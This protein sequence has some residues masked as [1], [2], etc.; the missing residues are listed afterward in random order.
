MAM[1]RRG[2]LLALAGALLFLACESG[3]DFGPPDS[4]TPGGALTT[5]SVGATL[6]NIA[7][8]IQDA[9]GRAV[10]GETVTWSVT[11]GGTTD[12][13]E[14][15]TDAEG[16]AST[17][18]TLGTTAGEQT[19]TA[20]AGT[21]ETT[22]VV[23][24]RPLPLA[25]LSIDHAGRVLHALEDTL[26]LGLIAEDEFGNAVDGIGFTWSSLEAAIATVDGGVV[27]ATGEGSAR[28]V[29]AAGAMFADT[30][31][32]VVDQ[33]LAR[34]DL[35]PLQPRVLAKDESL[36]LAAVPVD[37]NG[38]AID[39]AL[40]Y[41]WSSTAPAVAPVSASGLV[42][43]LDVGQAVIT[44]IAG[45]L[46]GQAALE[47][48]AGP[49]PSISAIAPAVID[50]GDTITITGA[51]FG[52]TPAGNAVTVA[53]RAATVLTAGATQITAATDP[54]S[55]PC[56]P[57]SDLEVAVDV[58]GLVAT[59]EHP[60]AGAARHA[61]ALGE[62]V[63]LTGLHVRCNELADDAT[64]VVSV[65]NT[66]QSPSATTAFQLRG[67]LSTSVTAATAA[68]ASSAAAALAGIDRRRIELPTRAPRQRAAPEDAAHGRVLDMSL[69]VLERL[70][71]PDLR[72]TGASGPAA[73]ATAAAVPTVGDILSLRIP[74][75]DEAN[76]CTDYRPVT[77]RVAYV[78]EYGVVLE[79]TVSPLAGQ[80]D[81]HW[82][83]IGSEYDGAMHQVLLDYFGDP[84]VLDG[85]LDD[86]DRLLM[87]FSEEVND[88]DSNV[89]G[90]VF[91]GDFY[92]RT[93]CA[94]SDRAEIFYG[95]VPTSTGPSYTGN[96]VNAWRRT[97]RST[98]IHEVKH[99]LSFASRIHQGG[100]SPSYEDQWL[101]ESTARLAEE[102]FARTRYG[103]TQDQNTGYQE[104]L[105]CE[106]RPTGFV[107]CGEGSPYVMAKHFFSVHDYYSAIEQLTPIGKA[108]A[109]DFSFYGSGWLLVRWAIDQSGQDEATFV[110]D[111]VGEPS[112][113]GVA[114][115]AARTGRPFAD[116]LGDFALAIAI[117]D[118]AGVTPLRAALSFPSWDT[119]EIFQRLYDDFNDQFPEQFSSPFPL[120]G[121]QVAFGDFEVSV[122]QLRG[123]TASF[124]EVDGLARPGSQLLELVSASGGIAPSSLGL[125]I[126]RVQ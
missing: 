93:Q 82:A 49:R 54:A 55:V 69:D 32:V 77:A 39:T 16:I 117:D 97:M 3:P 110:K 86:N 87:L 124:V 118:R 5:A 80:I 64:Y 48:R 23:L 34:L 14:T 62:S 120:A 42:H 53:G 4:L 84:L 7:V 13:V 115:L 113:A 102:F 109:D 10:P 106:V 105:F 108:G 33:V 61:L 44:A 99:I 81:D 123:G 90:F 126:V 43:A 60:V 12:P 75:I 95:I 40:S 70:G 96:T 24:A 66:T 35:T 73:R 116:M 9:D 79:D 125:A 47:V 59:R 78:G 29:V 51:G 94:S 28:I 122:G 45:S 98:V 101:E 91:S 41:A 56:A 20:S 17:S 46:Q 57:T 83:A 89:A 36:Q 37:S 74:D 63:T 103:Y 76:A 85:Q 58:D 92:T 72:A 119:R 19:L 18:W 114:N 52:A 104:S 6:E 111:L 112:L 88:F 65:F 21:L 22:F 31:T 2:H 121:R 30:V 26:H 15:R 50:A 25:A 100:G 1:I 67:T 71:P 68:T 11:G 8:T 38:F 107:A 27:T